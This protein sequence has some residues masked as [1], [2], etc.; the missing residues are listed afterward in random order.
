MELQYT[1]FILFL[2]SKIIVRKLF[3]SHFDSIAFHESP[4]RVEN[5]GFAVAPALGVQH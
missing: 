2:L 5:P 3:G 4:D 1:N